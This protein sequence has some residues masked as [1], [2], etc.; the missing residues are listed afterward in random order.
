MRD[1]WAIRTIEKNEEQK[2][3]KLHVKHCEDALCLKLGFRVWPESEYKLDYEKGCHT[4][5]K[6]WFKFTRLHLHRRIEGKLGPEH[7]IESDEEDINKNGEFHDAFVDE[8][9]PCFVHFKE[10]ASC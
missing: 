4:N 9:V 3:E 5:V 8:G 7:E 10:R 6:K 2:H 1:S